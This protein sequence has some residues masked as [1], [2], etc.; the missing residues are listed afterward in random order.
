MIPF[1][2]PYMT[3]QEHK[4]IDQAHANRKLAGDGIFTKNCHE[5]LERCV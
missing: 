3:G 5:W 2:R 4:Y 1:N